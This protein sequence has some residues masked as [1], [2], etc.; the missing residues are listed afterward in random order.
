MSSEQS[1]A[2]RRRLRV[3]IGQLESGSDDADAASNLE[4]HVEA[5][6]GA[7]KTGAELIVFPE[8]SLSGYHVQDPVAWSERHLRSA[9]TTL[10]AAAGDAT[11]IVG[12]PVA[13][14]AFGGATNSAL[15]VGRDGVIHRQDKIYLPNYNRYDE[16]DR[17]EAGTSLDLV[18]VAGFRLGIII[19]EDTWHPSL[20]YLARLKGADVLVHP[21]ASVEGAIGAGFSSADGWA[22]ITRAEALC[23][24]VYVIFANLAG[25]DEVATFWGRSTVFRPTG[26]VLV[27]AGDDPALASGELDGRELGEARRTLPMTDL[28]DIA[29]AEALLA[30]A[31]D[32]RARQT[33]SIREGAS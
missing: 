25:S 17:F 21:A 2:H 3:A 33:T 24:A 19:C 1:D 6:A 5:V 28:E 14:G 30:E 15:V 22:T 10:S 31:K 8:L 27:R 4:R 11:V 26:D 23:H 7:R 29:L 18:E 12:A 32:F 20:A 13:G 9:V 16:G